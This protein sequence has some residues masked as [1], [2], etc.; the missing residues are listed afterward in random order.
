MSPDP[1]PEHWSIIVTKITGVIRLPGHILG[2]TI[3]EFAEQR[4]EVSTTVVVHHKVLQI[5]KNKNKP[6]INSL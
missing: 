5:H 4:Q 3:L 2:K 6:I 1:D